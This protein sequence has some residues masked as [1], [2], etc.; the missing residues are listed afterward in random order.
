MGMTI[1]AELHYGYEIYDADSGWLITEAGEFGEFEPAWWD[2]DGDGL[3]EQIMEQL[4][5]A[6]GFT[7]TSGADDYWSR[8][9]EVERDLPVEVE[10]SGY[11][12]RQLLLVVKDREFSADAGEAEVIDPAVM[13]AQADEAANALLADALRT[14]GITPKQEKPAWLLTCYYG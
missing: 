3:G 2:E 9:W 6:A 4:V 11:E 10:H 14:L 12:G 7:E 1:K 5:R 13:S 8:R